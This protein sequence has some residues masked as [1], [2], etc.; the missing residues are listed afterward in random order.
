MRSKDKG[1]PHMIR[2]M[3]GVGALME[4]SGA[5]GRGEVRSGSRTPGYNG[6]VC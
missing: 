4:M 6:A 2:F 1:R 3:T 5:G